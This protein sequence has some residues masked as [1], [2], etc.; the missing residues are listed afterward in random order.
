MS[1]AGEVAPAPSGLRVSPS[2]FLLCRAV[3]EITKPLPGR[4]LFRC[5][6]CHAANLGNATPDRLHCAQCGTDWL[7]IDGIHRFR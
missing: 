5:P 7:V 6:N 1:A 4:P 3:G 2:Q